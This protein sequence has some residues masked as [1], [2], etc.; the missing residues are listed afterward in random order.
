MESEVRNE[1]ARLA[2]LLAAGKGPGRFMGGLA[3]WLTSPTVRTPAF[4]RHYGDLDLAART[5]D[6]G[7]IQAFL[8]GEGYLPDKRF[9][10]LY[11]AHRL[12]YAAPSGAWT[13]DVI[14]DKLEMSHVLDLRDRLTLPGATLPLADLLLSKLQI[15]EINRK[16]IADALCL[17]ADHP[18]AEGGHDTIDVGRITRVLSADWGFCHTVERNLGKVAELAVAEQV[19]GT[20]HDVVGQVAQLTAAI[21]A[22]PKSL[23]WKARA[24]VGERV[25]W[26][27]TPEEIEH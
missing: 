7:A 15:W 1:V 22:T 25:L 14:F 19:A 12:Y 9:N 16:D 24:R 10:T 13:V 27:D 5:N 11:G 26:Y 20:P 3:V 17:L 8:E 21:A 2:P 18:I 4:E 6:R 23:A